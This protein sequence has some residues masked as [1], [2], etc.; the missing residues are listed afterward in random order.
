M[1]RL[2]AQDTGQLNGE[3]GEDDHHD[4]GTPA[5]GSSLAKKAINVERRT[6]LHRLDDVLDALEELNLSEAPILS[7]AVAETLDGLGIKRA[8]V[9]APFSAL[10]DDVLAAQ[11]PFMI[12]LPADRRRRRWRV[13]LDPDSLRI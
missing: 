10:I 12:H 4:R 7:A 2:R 1:F 5:P 8:E 6:R 9:T 13:P 3:G 11:E